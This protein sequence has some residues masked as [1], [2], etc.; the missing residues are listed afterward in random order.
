MAVVKLKLRSL[1]E[2]TRGLLDTSVVI[3][4]TSIDQSGYRLGRRSA[5]LLLTRIEGRSIPVHELIPPELVLR[6][7]G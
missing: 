3:D 2:P 4:L 7:S 5:E 1:P 6:S